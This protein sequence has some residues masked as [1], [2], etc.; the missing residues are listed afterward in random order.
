MQT[1]VNEGHS[2]EVLKGMPR[3]EITMDHWHPITAGN[4]MTGPAIMV[5]RTEPE[6]GAHRHMLNNPSEGFHR[7]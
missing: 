6:A 5:G 3:T 1:G 2:H 7:S 4:A